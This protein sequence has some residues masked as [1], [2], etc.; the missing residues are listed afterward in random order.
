M[1]LRLQRLSEKR[2]HQL[3][4]RKVGRNRDMVV[5]TVATIHR[6]SLSYVMTTEISLRTK[7]S[8]GLIQF[9]SISLLLV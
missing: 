8:N 7:T 6:N 3:R 9:R 2:C 4:V 5:L 1:C